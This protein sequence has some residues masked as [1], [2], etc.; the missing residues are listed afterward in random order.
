MDPPNQQKQHNKEINSKLKKVIFFQL[1]SM[2]KE[3]GK[4][5]KGSHEKVAQIHGIAALQVRRAYQNVVNAIKMCRAANGNIPLNLVF[6]SSNKQRCSGL[7][8]SSSSSSC[9]GI[10]P[11][12]LPSSYSM[13]SS[14]RC[15]SHATVCHLSW[16]WLLVQWLL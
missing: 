11:G 3:D 14:G 15:S 10:Q 16:L 8:S 5:M 12:S 9:S 6:L 2:G 7:P 1:V 4:L 13:G